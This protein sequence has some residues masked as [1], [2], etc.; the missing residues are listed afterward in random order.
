MTIL[1]RHADHEAWK[2]AQRTHQLEHASGMR[3]TL[4][5]DAV[6]HLDNIDVYDELF[7]ADARRK[8]CIAAGRPW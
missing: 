3:P 2:Q 4:S 5:C 7:D 1:A 6:G 8:F